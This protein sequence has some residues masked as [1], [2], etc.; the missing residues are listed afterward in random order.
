MNWSLSVRRGLWSW[1]IWIL[2]MSYRAEPVT[3]SSVIP[4]YFCS[5]AVI[6]MATMIVT[7]GIYVRPRVPSW[8]FSLLHTHLCVDDG[9]G[10]RTHR[11]VVPGMSVMVQNADAPYI[12]LPRICLYDKWAHPIHLPPNNTQSTQVFG[13][14]Q[15]HFMGIFFLIPDFVRGNSIPELMLVL[16]NRDHPG[17]AKVSLDRINDFLYKV[18]LSL[19]IVFL[20]LKLY[21]WSLADRAL[22]QVLRGVQRYSASSTFIRHLYPPSRFH[23]V[24][25]CI[26]RYGNLPS[27]SSQV[28]TSNWGWSEVQT[29]TR[30]FDYRA[31][32]FWQD[33]FAHGVIG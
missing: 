24:D 26:N 1:R 25:G 28:R 2:G 15:E 22:G 19:C 27:F 9:Y 4:I 10:W 14:V 5:S 23:L 3:T 21:I 18:C 20:F 16:A 30:Q 6:P 29:W 31:N 7:Y 33:I 32:W 8:Q 17:L 13:T 12:S 11:C